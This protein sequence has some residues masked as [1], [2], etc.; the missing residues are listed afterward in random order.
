MCRNVISLGVVSFFTDIHSE[1]I[2]ALLPQFMANVLGLRKEYIGLIEGFAEATASLLKIASGWLSD[3]LGKRKSLVLAGYALSTAVKPLLAFARVGWHV[4][5]VRIG[6]RIGKGIR[7]SARDALIAEATSPEQRGRAFG[8]HRAMDTSGAIVGTV[9]AMV[10]LRAFAGDYRMVFLSVTIAGVL[11]TSTIVFGVRETIPAQAEATQPKPELAGSFPLF[12]VAHT[13]FSA[14]NFTYAFFLLRAQDSGVSVALVPALYLLHNVIYAAA[15]YP[16][17]ALM[18][19]FGPRR[20]LVAGYLIHAGACA[21]FAMYSSP[22]L[23]PVWFAVYGLQLAT[24]QGCVRGIAAGLARADRRGLG[25]GTFHACEGFGLLAGSVIGGLLW[26]R[27]GSGAAPFYYGMAMALAAAVLAPHALPGPASGE[28][29]S[30][31]SM[32]QV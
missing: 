21:G 32:G 17:G 27:M 4:L 22:L 7:S 25:M 20:T 9:L 16:A 13:V 28:Q 15:A 23:M 29:D 8:F 1:A 30:Q 19:K 3:R 31:A 11:A 10:L 14:G 2:L 5:G 12:L 18:D 6:D 24:T 26:E